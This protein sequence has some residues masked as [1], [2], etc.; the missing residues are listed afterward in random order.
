MSWGAL[1]V[2]GV[3]AWRGGPRPT[4]A[5]EAPRKPTENGADAAPRARFSRARPGR[6]RRHQDSDED[7]HRD[8]HR[9]QD[10]DTH[11]HGDTASE[12]P[13]PYA[14]ATRRQAL[15]RVVLDGGAREVPARG[16][17]TLGGPRR[18]P[19]FGLE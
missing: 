18:A 2:L 6:V 4:T 1:V 7:G 9:H 5:G 17:H 15:R 13:H 11:D 16:E 14:A 10:R 8:Q 12:V 3:V 19:L